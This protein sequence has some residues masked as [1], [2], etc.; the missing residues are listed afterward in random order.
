[1]Y[2]QRAVVPPDTMV[3]GRRELFELSVYLLHGLNTDELRRRNFL[4]P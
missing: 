3:S 2:P 1:M 4:A